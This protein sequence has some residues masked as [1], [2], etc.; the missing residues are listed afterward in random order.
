MSVD[1]PAMHANRIGRLSMSERAAAI[2]R[3][4]ARLV[5]QAAAQRAELAAIQASLEEPLAW[6][7][8]GLSVVRSIQ[9]H[10][11]I[12]LLSVLAAS[13][14]M[15]RHIPKA[16]SWAVRGLAAYQ[17]CKTVGSGFLGHW[18]ASSESRNAP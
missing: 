11:R 7:R 6:A 3:R 5:E 13:L 9:T 10:P 12:I 14:A 4:Q 1:L 18:R 8:K 16:H 15:G 17:L 2:S